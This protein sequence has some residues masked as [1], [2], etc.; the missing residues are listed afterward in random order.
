MGQRGAAAD[1]IGEYVFAMRDQVLN[2]SDEEW[3]RILNGLSAI[4]WVTEATLTVDLYFPMAQLSKGEPLR[5]VSRSGKVAGF[6]HDRRL[7]VGDPR[8][9][10]ADATSQFADKLFAP[11]PTPSRPRPSPPRPW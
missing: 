8:L 9:V 7:V 1:I 11:P 4:L 10:L 5:M 6:Y 2:A 3:E